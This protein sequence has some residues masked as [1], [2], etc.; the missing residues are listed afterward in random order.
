MLKSMTGFGRCKYENDGREYLVEIKSVN[1]RYNDINIKMP[2]NIGFLEE[3]VKKSITNSLSRGKID[4]YINFMN[5]SDKGKEIKINREMALR[6]IDELK[7]IQKDTGIIDNIGVMDIAKMPDVLNLK[8]NDE[9]DDLLWREL[10]ECLNNAITG[11]V[12]MRET[13]GQKIKEDLEER[14]N[15]ITTYIEKINKISTGLVEE[16]IVKLEK[17]V[18]ELLKNT[19]V[20]QTR[21]AQEIVIYSDKCSIEEELTRLRSHISQFLSLLNESNNP[22]GKKLDFLIQEMNRETN[23]IG[24]KANNLEITNYVV[25]IKTEIE[26]IREQV[27]NI[28]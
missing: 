28:E 5:Y 10:S 13:E 25:D 8:S 24:S 14:I 15:L 20:D 6:Y 9:D 26:N 17:R 21:L 23:T 22:V 18:N 3:N 11:L 12:L 16:Y 2:R 7:N 19:V 1:N 4:V 27:Q